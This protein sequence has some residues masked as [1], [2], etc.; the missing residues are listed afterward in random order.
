[1]IKRPLIGARGARRLLQTDEPVGPH[2]RRAA[3]V[4]AALAVG[5]EE[6]AAPDAL[7]AAFA[8]GVG[9]DVRRVRRR[10]GARVFRVGV[11]AAVKAGAV[12]LVLSGGTIAAAAADILPGS[13]QQ[14]AHSLFG[15]W[16][17]PAPHTPP[18]TSPSP[19]PRPSSRASA[20]SLSLSSTGHA[21]AS[22]GPGCS[23]RAHAENGRCTEAASA[24]AA[25]ASPGAA[26]ASAGAGNAHA[27]TPRKSAAH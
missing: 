21:T 11:S 26:R 22:T 17:V 3:Q 25:A 1:M 14:I 2:E 16:G 18:A 15:S 24:P 27:P 9:E 12:V 8:H 13:A 5:E 10:A 19:Q 7:V 6:R 23:D 4:L 20:P